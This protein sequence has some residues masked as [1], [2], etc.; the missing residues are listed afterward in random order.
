MEV[1][2]TSMVPSTSNEPSSLDS[3]RF[4]RVCSQR[5]CGISLWPGS[6][7]DL[8]DRCLARME[9]CNAS[10]NP[11]DAAGAYAK[12]ASRVEGEFRNLKD[13]KEVRSASPAMPGSAACSVC[14]DSVLWI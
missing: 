2:T 1:Y 12:T 8:C 7:S 9:V 11:R 6:K 3:Q 13:L 4:D 14:C 5:F 10:V